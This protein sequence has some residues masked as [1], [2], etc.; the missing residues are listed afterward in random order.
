MFTH[1]KA[2]SDSLLMFKAYDNEKCG[3]KSE[4]GLKRPR[5]IEYP[6]QQHAALIEQLDEPAKAQRRRELR[7]GGTLESGPLVDIPIMRALFPTGIVLN[8]KLQ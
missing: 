7:N 8:E 1:L 2:Y 6:S 3:D 5:H 4:L